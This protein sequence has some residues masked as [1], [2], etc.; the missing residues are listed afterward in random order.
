LVASVIGIIRVFNKKEDFKFSLPLPI[1]AGKNKSP[2]M[3]LDFLGNRTRLI[4]D[5]E[6]EIE[7]EMRSLAK[8]RKKIG[9]I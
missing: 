3:H 8:L 5:M 7:R 9:H 2:K 4:F 6:R 1:I